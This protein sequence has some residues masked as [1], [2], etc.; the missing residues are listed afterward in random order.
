MGCLEVSKEFLWYSNVPTNDLVNPYSGWSWVELWQRPIFKHH[1]HTA[2]VC[3][4]L[5]NVETA[6]LWHNI[7]F[8]EL[9]P[10]QVSGFSLL[11]LCIPLLSKLSHIFNISL[12][13]TNFLENKYPCFGEAQIINPNLAICP[14]FFNSRF[15]LLSTLLGLLN[16]NPR[17]KKQTKIKQY[18]G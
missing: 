10:V 16:P 13:L 17:C 7:Q 1:G 8:K 9:F 11:I 6:I 5:Q 18:D 4:W 3:K 15:L 14:C 12:L 2:S